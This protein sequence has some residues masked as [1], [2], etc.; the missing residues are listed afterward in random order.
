MLSVDQ[1][2]FID[3]IVV[4]VFAYAVYVFIKEKGW[5]QAAF[6]L[7]GLLTIGVF[8]AVISIYFN[9]YAKYLTS[10]I[11]LIFGIYLWKKKS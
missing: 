7:S 5:K 8:L 11:V 2:E 6:Y 3:F 4:F 9:D 1:I 10:A